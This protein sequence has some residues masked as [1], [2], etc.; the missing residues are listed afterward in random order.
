VRRAVLQDLDRVRAA[1]TVDLT[2]LALR[3][4]EVTRQI[5]E[6]PLVAAAG[7]PAAGLAAR[8]AA[9]AAGRAASA[10]AAAPT[11]LLGSMQ[12]L[13]EHVWNE[14][15]Q[16]VRVTRIEHPEA[17]LLAPEQALYLR[18]NLRLRLLNARLS[19][20][21]RQFDGAQADLRQAQ[22]LLDKYF[23]RNS[24]RVAAASESLKQAAAQARTVVVPRPE[25]TI[26]ALA[27]AAAGR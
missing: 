26:A 3:L 8:P 9:T 21:S 19:L 14:A 7:T 23:D 11:G 1:G 17:A 10:P 6:L 16:L 27:T 2:A 5:D 20:L 4:D 15:R 13:A 25:A 22:A 18:E 24:R 12:S